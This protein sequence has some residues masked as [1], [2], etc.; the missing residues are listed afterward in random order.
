MRRVSGWTPLLLATLVGCGMGDDGGGGTPP[1]ITSFTAS[2]SSISAAGEA[3]TLSWSVS[4]SV[5][6]FELDPGVGTVSGSSQVVNPTATTTYTLTATNSAGSDQETVTV[7]LA[8][9]PVPPPPPVADVVPPSGTFGV[10]ST[11]SDFQNDA[12]GVITDPGDP[13]IVRVEPGGTFYAEVAYS[14]PGGVAG[15]QIRLANRNPEGFAATLTPG[16]AVNGFTLV[17][18]LNGCDLSGSQTSVTCVYQIDVGDIPNIN[19]LPGSGNEFAYVLRV[20][21]SDVAGNVSNTPPRGYVIVADGSG[22]GTPPPSEPEPPAPPEEPG[23]PAPPE[24]PEP[25]EEPE[26]PAPPEEPEPPEEPFE[27][28]DCSDF[29]T[30]PEAQ[31]FFIAEG[32]P[33]EDPHQLDSDGDGIAC[34]S[35]PAS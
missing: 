26:P 29:E 12:D 21:V 18:E 13:R 6:S 23:P 5:T 1:R 33:E 16:Q 19:E 32:G 30:Q 4:G 25:P 31:A 22:G 7:T 10:S 28:R 35:L 27:D 2:P 8:E 3:V 34:E 17:D 24:D 11:P 20:N 14:D 9:A 15:V